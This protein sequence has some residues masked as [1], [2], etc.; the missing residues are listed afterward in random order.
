M[1]N[2]TVKFEVKRVYIGT[3]TAEE[4]FEGIFIKEITEKNKDLVAN[5]K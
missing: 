3:K 2:K 5:C 1:K 4:I